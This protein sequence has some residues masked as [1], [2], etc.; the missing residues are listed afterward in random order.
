MIP[1]FPLQLVCFPHEKLN[2][3]IFEP[4]YKQLV[5]DCVSQ[6]IP[7]GIVPVINNELQDIGTEVVILEKKNTYPDGEMDI[8]TVGTGLFRLYDTEKLMDGKLYGGGYIHPFPTYAEESSLVREGILKSIAQLYK[9]MQINIDLHINNMLPLSYQVAHKIGF[10]L[11]K[12]YELLALPHEAERQ[13]MI[14][15]H[16]THVIPILKDLEDA[17]ERIKLNGHF[18]HLD[19]LNF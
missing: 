11:K 10:S 14:V 4:R 17:K 12:E 9:I 19:K 8:S 16:L 15:D 7:F 18:K 1:L 3:H 6:Q 13:A 5:H 2:L